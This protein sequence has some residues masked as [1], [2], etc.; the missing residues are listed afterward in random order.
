MMFSVLIVEDNATKCAE[1]RNCFKIFP[2]LSQTFLIESTHSIAS[3]YRVLEGKPW[4]LIIL[5]MT[6][7]APLGSGNEIAKEA[8][9]GIELL[10]YMSK[11]RMKTPVIVATQHSSFSSTDMP[12]ID[13]IE[14]LHAVLSRLFPGNYRKIVQ[15]D[16]AEKAWKGRLQTAVMEVLNDA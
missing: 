5:D 10:Q 15:V 3:A 2:Q 16:L 8:L 9:A 13:S 7:Q 4:D 6:F 1:I 12:G 11:R 14:K